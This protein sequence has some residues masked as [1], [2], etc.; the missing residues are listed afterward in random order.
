MR[1][2]QKT[3]S[4]RGPGLVHGLALVVGLSLVCRPAEAQSGAATANSNASVGNTPGGAANGR[5][6]PTATR[7]AST[8][9]PP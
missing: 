5:A 1:A 7:V 3:R 6:P 8:S 4:G 9:T 2:W